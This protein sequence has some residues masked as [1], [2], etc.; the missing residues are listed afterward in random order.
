M[1]CGLRRVR[2]D[3]L[4]DDFI[5]VAVVQLPEI[6]PG[7]TVR[8]RLARLWRK[9]CIGPR[10][11]GCGFC[12]QQFIP[13]TRVRLHAMDGGLNL[14]A[15]VIEANPHDAIT[16]LPAAVQHPD[17]IPRSQI[18]LYPRQEGSVEADVA[19]LYFLQEALTSRINSPDSHCKVSVGARFT[20]AVNVT[21]DSHISLFTL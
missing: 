13:R 10:R 17:D 21:K 15:T 11:R 16:C 4:F 19:N 12:L 9:F 8:E 2:L 7:R 6:N 5:P 14:V 1:G 3:W 18:G 20:A